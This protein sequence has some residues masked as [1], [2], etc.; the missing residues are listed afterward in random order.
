MG[1]VFAMQGIGQLAAALVMMFLTLG[2]K[3]TLEGTKTV[4]ECTGDCQVAVDKMWRTL[5]GL[6]AVPACIALYCTFNLSSSFY[7]PKPNLAKNRPFN[8]PRDPPIHIRCQPRYREGRR[9]CQSL[10]A[11]KARGNPRRCCSGQRTEDC[12]RKPR[13]PQ[14]Q[15]VRLLPP[16]PQAKELPSSLGNCRLMVLS[17]C[18]LLWPLPQ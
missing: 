1:A 16:L 8:H 10:H 12:L 5:V 3:S 11:R 4:A 6:G 14:S 13:S 18:S 2:F 17:R 7:P 15:L 9:R